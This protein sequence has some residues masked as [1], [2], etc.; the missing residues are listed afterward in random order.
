MF[1]AEG[2]YQSVQSLVSSLS[3]FKAVIDF[4]CPWTHLDRSD[5]FGLDDCF[6]VKTG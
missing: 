5:K 3:G 1:G 4:V 2:A 6:L